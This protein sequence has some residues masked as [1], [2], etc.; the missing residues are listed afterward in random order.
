MKTKSIQDRRYLGLGTW[1]F[2]SCVHRTSQITSLNPVVFNH[3]CPLQDQWLLLTQWGR[4]LPVGFLLCIIHTCMDDRTTQS[5]SWLS[6]PSVASNIFN[7]YRIFTHT[8]KKAV[9]KK[10]VAT[11]FYK[12]F[13]S[14]FK[15]HKTIAMCKSFCILRAHQ[16]PFEWILCSRLCKSSLNSWSCLRS[17]LEILHKSS[18]YQ[19]LLRQKDTFIKGSIYTYNL[20][21]KQKVQIQP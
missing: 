5:N 11:E 3:I 20:K 2:P 19:T 12:H 21:R 13:N 10:P 14:V 9:L 6:I 7:S 4:W 1:N 15:T 18:K 16:H 17:I 8:Q